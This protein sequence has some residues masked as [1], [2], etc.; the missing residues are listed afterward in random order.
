M[1]TSL[2]LLWTRFIPQLYKTYIRSTT[3]MFAIISRITIFSAHYFRA[4]ADTIKK[5]LAVTTQYARARVSDTLR[6]HSKSNF[7]ACN[8]WR[9]NESVATDT[10]FSGIPAVDSCVK[11]AQL[12]IGSSSPVADV[13]GVKTYKAF[14]NT[15]EDNIHELGAM[16][17]LISD[18]ARAKNSTS[19][20]D[21]LCDLV[22]FDWQSE[23]YHENQHFAANR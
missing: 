16:D 15:L 8:I 6:Q 21:I 18:C 9:R 10:I 13:Y 11:A 22:I 5:T 23:P 4:P 19:I 3:L 1:M 14:S 20:R 12:F 7:P 17:K 2:M